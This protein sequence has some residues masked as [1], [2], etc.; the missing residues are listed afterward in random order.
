VVWAATA[1][2]GGLLVFWSLL[3]PIDRAPDEFTH[4]DLVFHLAE[5]G[6]Y[7][8]YDRRMVGAAARGIRLGQVLLSGGTPTRRNAE[9]RSERPTFDELGGDR[10]S[11][12][13]QPNQMPQHPPLYYRAA[14]LVVRVERA[15]VPGP[16]WSFEREWHLVRIFSAALVL[17]LPLLIWLAA[18]RLGASDAVSCAA[19]LFP[20]AIPQVAHVGASINNDT[21]SVLLSAMLAVLLAGVL[22]GRSTWHTAVAAG[23]VCGLAL[24]T[25]V[26]GLTLV[27]WVGLAYLAAAWRRP[28]RRREFATSA[29]IATATATLVGGWWWILNLIRY[30]TPTPSV[31]GRFFPDRP[32]FSPDV[33][34]W[35]RRAVVW[36]AE[37][38]WGTFDWLTVPMNRWVL[39]AASVVAV[40]AVVAAFSP[41]RVRWLRGPDPPLGRVRLAAYGS[42]VLI[43]LVPLVQATWSVYARSGRPQGLQGR[44][45]FPALVPIAILV[46]IGLAR[47]A[48]RWAPAL[49]LAWSLIMV[50]DGWRVAL[51]AWWGAPGASVVESLRAVDAWNPAAD[52]ATWAVLGLI[53]VS[54]AALVAA[55]ARDTVQGPDTRG[56]RP[57]PGG[58]PPL[59]GSHPP[60]PAHIRPS[61]GT[62]TSAA[63]T[64]VSI[65]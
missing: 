27:T 64:Q 24:L 20:L 61:L 15:V 44:Y 37:R 16:E 51:R 52:Q 60:R 33:A 50:L 14:A 9:S 46:A 43:L 59:P 57:P 17:P 19:A 3:T 8:E 28:S 13:V 58:G 55:V 54:F 41:Q 22:R 32:G 29:A 7:P 39:L 47:L 38:F 48:G 56:R 45:F 5:G 63:F 49:V 42:I 10:P 40:A 36:L 6:S 1:L 4:A 34:W 25:K 18:S 35:T 21:L 53:A 31:I 26:Y 12:W 30:G 11:E 23:F 2:F 65:R 62:P